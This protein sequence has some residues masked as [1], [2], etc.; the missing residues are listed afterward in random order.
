MIK[1]T[2]IEKEKIILDRENLSIRELSNKFNLNKNVILRVI[3]EKKNIKNID[4]FEKFIKSLRIIYEKK[5]LFNGLIKFNFYTKDK[6]I[7]FVENN[8]IIN[9]NKIKPILFFKLKDRYYN[10]IFIY[11]DEWFNRNLIFKEKIRYILKKS[12]K[13]KIYARKCTIKH[14][15][16]NEKNIFLDEFHLQK[17]VNS[18]INIGAFY[19]NIL[20]AVMT[21]SE[22]RG[23][24]ND[25]N[26]FDYELNRFATNINFLVVGIASKLFKYFLKSIEKNKLIVSYGDRKHVLN[27]KNNVYNKLNFK[28]NQI[29]K[30]DYSYVKY[31]EINKHHK[32]TMQH[33]YKKNKKINENERTYYERLGYKKIWDCGKYRFTYK[34]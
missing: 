10:S 11:E 31:N 33:H 12:N 34:S 5:V 13:L 3:N 15:T 21:F 14:I 27:R 25:N 20:V 23:L 7:F 29:S 22:N 32:F 9:N 18:S 2:D 8:K 19:N 4:D 17:K 16:T 24:T 30:H 1:L 6:T 28:L 26:K